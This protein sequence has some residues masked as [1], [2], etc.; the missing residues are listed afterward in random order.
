[1]ARKSFKTFVDKELGKFASFLIYALLEWVLIFILFIDGFLAFLANE[2]ARFFE[3]Q[4]PCL[5]CTRID[6]VLVHRAQDF[7]YNDSIC[8]SHKKDVSYLSYCHDHKKLSHIRKMC[9]NCLLSFASEKPSGSSS[10]KDIEML[11]DNDRDNMT[12]LAA[13]KEDSMQIDKSQSKCECCGEPLKMKLYVKGK[14]PSI[15]TQAPAPSPR[16]A[17]VNLRNR[18][19]ELPR[20]RFALE[21]EDGMNSPDLARE[22]FKDATMR[23]LEEGDDI[24]EDR[25]PNFGRGNKFFG[26]PLS[27]SPNSTPRLASRVLRKSPLEKTKFATKLAETNAENV[28]I[29]ESDLDDQSKV[30]A[31]LDRNTLISLYNEL[32]KERSASAIAA[33]NA[34]AMI[35]RLQTEKAEFQ[36]EALQYQ[37]LM[38][39]QAEYDQEAL[40]AAN[41]LAAK[42]EEDI[43]ALEAEL[44]VYREKFGELTEEDFARFGDDF[45]YYHDMNSSNAERAEFLSPTLSSG[46]VSSCNDQFGS[47][48]PKSQRGFQLR[49]FCDL[50]LSRLKSLNVKMNMNFLTDDDAPSP[51]SSSDNVWPG[52][53][54]KLMRL[55]L[56]LHERVKGLES[57]HEIEQIA[58]PRHDTEKEKLLT[59]ICDN[60]RKLRD[61]IASPFS[62]DHEA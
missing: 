58:S 43:R 6:H 38:E 32:D 14:A 11:L 30:Q 39:E 45:E 62:D 5:L 8:E 57:E 51:G 23:I 15:A 10:Y 44:D 52:Q 20:S 47:G 59:E 33:N 29:L 37:R 46:E 36:M 60:L 28:P 13:K 17:F 25:T 50:N 26:I 9:D 53:E 55:M 49:R 31:P 4:I 12:L 42:R 54:N 21:N 35:T 56:Q 48:T 27:D 40:Q 24:I 16:A 18:N 3:L 61:F 41:E 1:M 7:Y 19:V 34:M 22:D 2:F